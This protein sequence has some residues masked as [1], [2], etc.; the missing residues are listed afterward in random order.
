MNTLMFALAAAAIW[1]AEP[2]DRI[3]VDVGTASVPPA[4]WAEADPA[5][6]LYREARRALNAKEYEK[7]AELFDEIV[8]RYPR[9][10]YAADALYWKGFALYRDG[11][12]DDA[13]EALETQAKKYPRAATRRDAEALLVRVQGEL[14]KRGDSKA[15]EDVD[16]AASGAAKDCGDMEVRAA[17]L[18]ALQQMDSERVLPL[19]KKVLARRDECS[20]PLRKNALFILAQKSGPQREELLLEVAKNDPDPSVRSDAVFHLSQASSEEAVTALEQLLKS[21]PDRR[22]R[23]NALFALANNRSAR[24]RTILRDFALSPQEPMNLRNDAIFHLAQSRDD[25]ARQW[26]RQAYSRITES[27]LRTN[28]MFHIA[29]YGTEDSARWL[30]GVLTDPK[31]ATSQR[32]NALF[33]LSGMRRTTAADL[34]SAYE[35]VPE[36]IKK[37]VIFHLAGHRDPAALDKLIAIAKTDRDPDMRKD[38]LFHIAQSRDPRALKALEEIVTP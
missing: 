35:K 22:V 28:V 10:E 2:K 13:V 24:A 15:L 32:K 4:A 14:A 17:A 25:D 8:E 29:G 34:M 33:H 12:F 9:S 6:S 37:D 7:A 18:D 23:G 30:L 27:D 16:S 11:N 21:S 19:L 26:L 5:D 36:A 20:R 1:A 3:A 31:E 38:A